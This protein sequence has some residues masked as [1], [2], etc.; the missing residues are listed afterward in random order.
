MLLYAYTVKF[1]MI[2]VRIEGVVVPR[3]NV[4]MQRAV[5]GTL[6]VADEHV[7]N[8]SRH[9]RTATFTTDLPTKGEKLQL[10]D[11]S[12]LH[13]TDDTM[14]LSGFEQGLTKGGVMPCDYAQTWVLRMPEGDEPLGS[15]GPPYSR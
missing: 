13:C 9:V 14:V 12:L 1:D 6:R 7:P 8:L 10:F 5:R 11:V 15:M 4:G 3:H 2:R